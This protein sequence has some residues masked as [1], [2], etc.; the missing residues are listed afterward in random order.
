[1]SIP[2]ERRELQDGWVLTCR[3]KD[4]GDLRLS[5]LSVLR[6]NLLL[7]VL[8]S[9][10]VFQPLSGQ[11]VYIGSPKNSFPDSTSFDLSDGGE[12]KESVLHEVRELIESAQMHGAWNA[13]VGGLKEVRGYISLALCYPWKRRSHSFTTHCLSSHMSS[14]GCHFNLLV[15]PCLTSSKLKSVSIN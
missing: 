11:D 4:G 8:G 7:S 10:N 1:M 12:E 9:G 2:I 6:E 13:G 3:S 5:D 14:K 15:S